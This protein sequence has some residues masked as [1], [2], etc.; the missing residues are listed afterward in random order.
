VAAPVTK[1]REATEA[2]QTGWSLTP[3][4]TYL[5]NQVAKISA[6]PS[7]AD[8]EHR[9]AITAI[10]VAHCT[11]MLQIGDWRMAERR[12]F[13]KWLLKYVV[14]AHTE[15]LVVSDHPVRSF[16]EAARCRASR[17]GGFPAL[18]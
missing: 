6:Q 12:F 2:A 17:K 7:P 11:R 4:S 18:S 8:L 14:T 5:S 13:G 16:L 1:Y 15:A 3:V 10:D 9:F